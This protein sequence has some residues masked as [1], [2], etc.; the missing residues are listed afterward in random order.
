MKR[1]SARKMQIYLLIAHAGDSLGDREIAVRIPQEGR[2]TSW[3]VRKSYF[4]PFPSDELCH[5]L[6]ELVLEGRIEMIGC[7]TKNQRYRLKIR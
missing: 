2:K 6:G 5:V 3:T 7:K 4:G 1:R